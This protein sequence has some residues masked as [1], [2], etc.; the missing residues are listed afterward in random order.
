[1]ATSFADH[2]RRIEAALAD[3]AGSKPC[4]LSVALGQPIVLV[5]TVEIRFG[6]DVGEAAG[7]TDA[8]LREL[9]RRR[10]VAVILSCSKGVP[11]GE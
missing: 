7:L 5:G 11:D 3:V 9:I 4:S 6:I 2:R 10:I 8:G 1:M